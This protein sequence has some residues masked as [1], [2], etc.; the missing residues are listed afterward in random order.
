MKPAA[1][2]LLQSASIAALASLLTGPVAAADATPDPNAPKVWTRGADLPRG[3]AFPSQTPQWIGRKLHLFAGVNYRIDSVLIFDADTATW[4]SRP[5]ALITSRHHFAT[6]AFGG[7]IFVAGGCLG[8]SDSVPHRRTDAVESYDPATGLWT[9]RCP[10]PAPR[11]GFELVVF[12]NEILAIGGADKEEIPI[13]AIDAYDPAQDAWRHVT[14][15]P[16]KSSVGY[17]HAV[18]HGDRIWIVGRTRDAAVLLEYD[19]RANTFAEKP[20]GLSGDRL[21]YGVT[22]VGDTILLV[23]GSQHRQPSAGVVGYSIGDA[24][25]REFPPLPEPQAFAAAASVDGRV[26][27]IGGVGPTWNWAQPN[28]SVFVL[29]ADESGGAVK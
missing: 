25:W 10:M 3:Q 2:R 17:G 20:V 19:P 13:T 8:E 21:S 29:H 24:T 11:Q 27:C 26:L 4:E 16:W 14:T 12:G 15:A 1:V 23:G 7:R 18:V 5:T 6:A 22:I 28:R 9:P